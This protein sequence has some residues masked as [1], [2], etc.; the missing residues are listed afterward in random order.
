MV[1]Q[2]A[3]VGACLTSDN[4]YSEERVNVI[5]D[6]R[7][8]KTWEK[9]LVTGAFAV[10]LFVNSLTVLAHPDTY[11]VNVSEGSEENGEGDV[12][13]SVSYD[14]RVIT[15]DGKVY[16]VN[17]QPRLFCIHNWQDAQYELHSEDGNG[18][19]TLRVYECTFCPNCNTVNVGDLLAI[20]R[21]V[22]CPHD[23]AQ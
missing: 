19:C 11:Q 10:M 4:K 6:K 13:G 3:S 2:K 20:H 9:M 14:E 21:Y 18:G 22:T 23:Y 5:M 8:R 7:K 1:K 16:P 12:S 15:A 17:A